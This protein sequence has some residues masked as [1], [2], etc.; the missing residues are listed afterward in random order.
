M[1]MPWC[2]VQSIVC[3]SQNSATAEAARDSTRW[4]ATLRQPHPLVQTDAV[5][6]G[7]GVTLN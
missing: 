5:C 6:T 3:S 4:L 1:L 7:S 2:S